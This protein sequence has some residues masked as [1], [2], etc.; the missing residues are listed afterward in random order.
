[1]IALPQQLSHHT[2]INFVEVIG[3]ILAYF[4][5]TKESFNYFIT[6]NARNNDI[7]LGHL[8]TVF[9]FSKDERQ[10]IAQKQKI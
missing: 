2:G 1:L 4:K 5:V 9:S 10:H 7:C 3:D 6:D 8:A